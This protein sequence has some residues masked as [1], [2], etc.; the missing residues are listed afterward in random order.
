MNVQVKFQVGKLVE[1]FIAQSTTVWFLPGMYEEVVTQI[2]FLM[3]TFTADLAHK[4]LLFAVCSNVRL[5]GGGAIE[6]LFTDVT[7]VWF[8]TGVNDFMAAQSA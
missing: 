8:V 6:G 1:S 2:T 4:V 5:Q 7:F 3:K